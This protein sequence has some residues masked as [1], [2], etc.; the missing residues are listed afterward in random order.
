MSTPP[1]R[2][3]Q[4]AGE[5]QYD[6]DGTVWLALS[7]G[8]GSPARWTRMDALAPAPRVVK[9]VPGFSDLPSV[10]GGFTE[11]YP[12]IDDIEDDDLCALAQDMAILLHDFSA[13]A[14]EFQAR[15]LADLLKD[16]HWRP[17]YEAEGEIIKLNRANKELTR[18]LHDALETPPEAPKPPSG[19]FSQR[20]ENI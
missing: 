10:P 8:R 1:L 13:L 3:P 9:P 18:Q 11:E 15:K 12:V 2:I 14:P 16:L 6:S 19:I 20:V 5:V 4:Y 17:T 7:V